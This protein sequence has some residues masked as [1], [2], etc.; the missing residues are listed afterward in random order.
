MSWALLFVCAFVGIPVLG[1]YQNVQRKRGL[2]LE[3]QDFAENR[4]LEG[5]EPE[6]YL[7]AATELKITW[8]EG[9]GT[10]VLRAKGTVHHKKEVVEGTFTL[11]CPGLPPFELIPQ[12]DPTGILRAVA[13]AQDVQVGERSFDDRWVIQGARN[14]LAVRLVLSPRA[15]ERIAYLDPASVTVMRDELVVVKRFPRKAWPQASEPATR[16]MMGYALQRAGKDSGVQT[17][18]AALAVLRSLHGAL[19]TGAWAESAEA[20][21]LRRVRFGLY[22]GTVEDVLGLEPGSEG[23]MPVELRLTGEGTRI[24]VQVDSPLFAAH[25]DSDIRVSQAFSTKNPV[26]DQLIRVGG[27]SE[28][29]AARLEDEAFL[30]LLLGVVHGWPGS[31]VGKEGVSLFSRDVLVEGLEEAVR[32]S[33]RLGL[34]LRPKR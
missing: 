30:E 33:A 23:R 24:R 9:D 6:L 3:L 20:L 21:S 27:D 8:P 13:G 28:E 19:Q 26:V 31:W 4:R 16:G 17:L 34:A 22:E 10:A 12:L 29:V 18:S 7:H 2:Q 1:W 14:P 11:P 15:R 32:L 25:K 5:R